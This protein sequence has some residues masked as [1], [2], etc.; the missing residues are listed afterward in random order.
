MSEE[1]LT[2]DLLLNICNTDGIPIGGAKVTEGMS[3][4]SYYMSGTREWTEVCRVGT[5]YSPDMSDEVTVFALVTSSSSPTDDYRHVE[6]WV[7]RWTED[8][9]DWGTNYDSYVLP[10]SAL[11]KY[12]QRWLKEQR[13]R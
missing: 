7:V 8:M 3:Y 10:Y 9:G 4:D 5:W 13:Q 1:M 11:K 6:C 12:F 2:T